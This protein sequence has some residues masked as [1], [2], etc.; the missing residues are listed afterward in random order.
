MIFSI[1]LIGK[2]K[3]YA[4]I[5]KVFEPYD[6][7]VQSNVTIKVEDGGLKKLRI[8]FS[9]FVIVLYLVCSERKHLT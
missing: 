7:Q 9:Y 1:N 3:P 5:D 6:V 2:R 8:M 4:Y